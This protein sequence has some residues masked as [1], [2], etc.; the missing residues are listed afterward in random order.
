MP[1]HLTIS[2]LLDCV[3]IPSG[4]LQ[5]TEDIDTLRTTFTIESSCPKA[6]SASLLQIVKSHKPH[7]PQAHTPELPPTGGGIIAKQETLPAKQ[8]TLPSRSTKKQLPPEAAAAQESKTEDGLMTGMTATLDEAGFREVQDMRCPHPC[9]FD[10]IRRVIEQEG[11]MV[12][13][14]PGLAGFVVWFDAPEDG[15]SY[16]DLVQA[17][18][19][20]AA[21]DDLCS[22]LRD[23]DAD[24][25]PLPAGCPGWPF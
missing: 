19:N 8:E 4:V 12:C 6:S 18:H 23:G 25:Q 7:S 2:L 22:F 24:C 1:S 14:E 20:A 3:L 5:E 9:M 13:H 15:L 21:T 10:F 17:L 16:E 11:Y